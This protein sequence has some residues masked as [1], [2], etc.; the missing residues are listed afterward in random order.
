MALTVVPAACNAGPPNTYN[1]AVHPRNDWGADDDGVHPVRPDPRVRTPSGRKATRPPGCVFLLPT[2]T[3]GTVP[4][5][6]EVCDEPVRRILRPFVDD[7][8]M[9]KARPWS[10]PSRDPGDRLRA[11]GLNVALP[12]I[13]MVA[14]EIRSASAG[15]DIKAIYDAA[16]P[17]AAYAASLADYALSSVP[18]LW[19][20]A[21]AIDLAGLLHRA[22]GPGRG[23]QFC[24]LID[25]NAAQIPIDI[26][27]Y[28]QEATTNS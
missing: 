15:S 11:S 18:G 20:I 9:R 19:W 13:H 25:L 27:A 22:V 5:N 14:P 4:A 1:R 23:L 8:R 24:R 2:Y 7:R 10:A 16:E 6:Y 12:P 28:I 21:P 17:W 26:Q 3:R